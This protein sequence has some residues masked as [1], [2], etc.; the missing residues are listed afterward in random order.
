[1]TRDLTRLE[2]LFVG[3]SGGAAVAGAMKYARA[4][5]ERGEGSVGGRPAQHPRLPG[6]RGPQVPVEDLQR[7][8]D[9]RE[10]LP[11]GRAGH[12]HGARHPRSGKKP[13]RHRDARR[14]APRGHRPDEDAR[15]QPAPGGRQAAS[16]EGIVAEVDLLRAPRQR[17]ARRSSRRSREVVEDD[18]ATVTPNTKIELLQGVLADAKVAIVEERDEVVGIVTKI[19]LIDF[20]AKRT[21]IPSIPP[22]SS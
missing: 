2:G 15:H 21:P 20:L 14:E 13:H 5:D 10:R 1:M 4:M 9:A 3:G 22:P 11:R 7:R 19:D 17:A 16:C 6:R 8:L 12:R 18:Y